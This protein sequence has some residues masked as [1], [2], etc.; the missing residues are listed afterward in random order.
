MDDET[1][2][3]VGANGQLGQALQAQY[4][5]ATAVDSRVLDITDRDAVMSYDWS[6]IHILLNA[7]GYTNVDG[8]ESTE[9]RVAAWQVNAVGTRNLAEA[10]S[11]YDLTLVHV[12][13]DYVFDGTR[14]PH[15][16]D[17]ALSPLGVYAQTKAAADVAASLVAKQ[18]TLRTSWIVGD[19]KNFVR[20]ILG[21]G[22]RG[23]APTVVSDQIGRLTFTSEIAKVVDH[24]LTNAIPYGTYNVS[25]GGEPASWAEVTREVFR[26]AGYDLAVTDTSTA[27][28][29]ADK[30][31]ASPRP[32]QSTLALEKLEA[33]GFTP[34]DW[35][36]NLKTYVTKELQQS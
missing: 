27:A 24:L 17:E 22:Q 23:I 35:R 12:S 18:Y 30:P 32:L 13:T 26:A 33:T 3:I 34:S 6:N 16:E 21:L 7:A 15:S 28:Y 5:G 31:E 4:P 9:G 2:F 36:E 19:G 11:K 29:F 1:I 25:N 10:A 8:A 20:T 14:S